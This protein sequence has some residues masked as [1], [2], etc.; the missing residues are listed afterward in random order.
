MRGNRAATQTQRMEALLAAARAGN[1]PNR[2][3]LQERFGISRTQATRD[4]IAL[5][6]LGAPL[7]YDDLVSGY[8]LA[9]PD[10]RLPETP[11]PPLASPIQEIAGVA[12]RALVE[13]WNPQLANLL[14]GDAGAAVEQALLVTTSHGAWVQPTMLVKLADA[15]AN[16]QR[17]HIVYDP[18]W[19]V[20]GA[21]G[22]ACARDV[23]PWL[24]QVADGHPYLH[25][26]CH[27]RRGHRAF[28]LSGLREAVTLETAAKRRPI[29]L[30]QRVAGRF[31]VGGDIS[32]DKTA[33][34]Q[35]RG[36]WAR[37]VERE[38][39]HPQQADSWIADG[40]LQRRVRFGLELALVR[41]L[42]PGGADVEVIAPPSLVKAWREAVAALVQGGVQ[43]VTA[44]KCPGLIQS[45]QPQA[46]PAGH[47]FVRP[48]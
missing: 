5:R 15:I 33:T 19:P 38:R 46:C 43:G 34:V 6:D 48:L 39:W 8:A 17:L 4:I 24:I 42:L 26:Y 31:G 44:D 23:S 14:R 16:Q 32:T 9:D 41:R 21:G 37:W 30:R 7:H 35:L 36:A 22:E 18:A 25:A 45:P 3:W 10:W 11:P 47:A 20:G 12:A 40:V 13:A 29:D 28:H 27:L 2:R 1:A